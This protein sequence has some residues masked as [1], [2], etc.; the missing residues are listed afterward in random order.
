MAS[1][2][3]QT[4]VKFNQIP[5]ESALLKRI[6]PLG[7]D[8]R[9]QYRVYGAY[10]P[11]Q[12]GQFFGRTVV[13]PCEDTIADPDTG[14]TYDIAYIEGVGPGGIPKVG[15]IIFEDFNACT[16][17]LFGNSGQDQR[18]YQYIELCNFLQ[19]N[20]H[21]DKNRTVL[22][23]RVDEGNDLKFKRDKRKKV[24][25]AL[26]IVDSL[27]SEEVLNFIRANR[28]ADPGTLEKRRAVLEDLAEK[29]PEKFAEMPMV[30]YTANYDLIDNAKQKKV[31]VWN[32]VSREWQRYDGTPIIQV[33]KGFGV[34]QKDELAMF[35]I[36]EEGKKT[37][38]WMKEEVA[39]K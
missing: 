10:D 9:V 1:T 6:K 11:Q 34:S 30:D 15:T 24:Q 23:E 7:K 33:K 14:E 26:A 5:K 17:T 19:D 28:I 29:T 12:P 3:A 21:R 2:I 13:L 32:N 4:P 36:K 20:P 31:I 27:T 39:K 22:I 38:A 37:L 35:L 25:A 16:I 18:K 8:E